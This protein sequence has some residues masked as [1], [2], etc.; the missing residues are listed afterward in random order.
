MRSVPDRTPAHVL[1]EGFAHH[2]QRWAGESGSAEAATAVAQRT[3]YLVSMATTNGHV[4]IDLGDVAVSLDDEFD[5]HTLRRALMDSG[6]VGTPE[7]RG[8]M[9]LILDADDR[10]TFIAIS[11]TNV[12]SPAAWHAAAPRAVRSNRRSRLG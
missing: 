2:V 3:A 7:A 10:V 9:P 4:C 1:A 6:V 5:L 12:A 8:A 11:I